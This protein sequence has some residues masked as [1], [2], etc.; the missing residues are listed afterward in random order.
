MSTGLALSVRTDPSVAILL[1]TFNGGAFLGEQLDSLLTQ[2]H[3]NWVL[4]WRDDGSCDQ[5][6]AV[7]AAFSAKAGQGRCVELRDALGH[8]GAAASFFILLRA[9]APSM[10]A[11]D[12]VAFADQDD[13]WF[14]RKLER[15]IAALAD[16]MSSKPALYCARQVLVDGALKPI[17]L[18]L[19]VHPTPGFSQALTQNIVTGCTMMLNRTAA[20]LVAAST[21]SPAVLHDWWCYLIVTGAGGVVLQDAEPVLF[22]RQHGGNMVGAP[23]NF[24]R[25]AMAAARRGRGGFMRVLRLN[26]AALRS[27]PGL[28]SAQARRDVN[29]LDAALCGGWRARMRALRMAGL[30]R[31]TWFE[32]LVFRAWL[33]LG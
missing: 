24:R 15:G 12:V 1:S 28:L 14:A 29:R 23:P 9:V 27:Q 3:E 25:R 13:V 26:V 5:T 17:G 20:W 33:I 4:H 7:M 19:P 8:Q 2:T 31:R 16:G 32:T 22:Y 11:G 30:A 6:R 10:A 18:S 21:P